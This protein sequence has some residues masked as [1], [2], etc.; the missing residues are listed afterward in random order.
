[1]PAF[2]FVGSML[3]R[4]GE[5]FLYTLKAGQRA[6]SGRPRPTI[7]SVHPL[8]AYLFG[9]SVRVV[10]VRS[11]ESDPF[12]DSSVRGAGAEARIGRTRLSQLSI[13]PAALDIVRK[14]R[15]IRRPG[16][17]SRLLMVPR[18]SAAAANVFNSPKLSRAVPAKPA[19]LSRNSLASP[20]S[21]ISGFCST[22][23]MMPFMEP[24]NSWR[25]AANV[26]VISSR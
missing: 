15:P 13:T 23:S 5:T 1:M 22:K 26:L 12:A 4:S 20:F 16:S 3:L 17:R 2:R 6:A 14:P 8:P 11:S 7:R 10:D 19:I 9:T 18:P 24:S 25:P 21:S